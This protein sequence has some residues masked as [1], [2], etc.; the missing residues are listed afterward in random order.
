MPAVHLF[1]YL[2]IYLFVA[3]LLFTF[4]F[5]LIYLPACLFAVARMRATA[6][7]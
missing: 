5:L 7:Q 6:W 3:L 2:F 4:Y 1:I